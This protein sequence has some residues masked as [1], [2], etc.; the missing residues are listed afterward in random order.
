MRT[1]IIKKDR[2]LECTP[3][4][5]EETMMRRKVLKSKVIQAFPDW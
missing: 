5:L 2:L 3:H 4:V 1:K